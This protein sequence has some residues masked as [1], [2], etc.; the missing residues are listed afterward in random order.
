MSPN[1][2]KG[3]QAMNAL[4]VIVGSTAHGPVTD[5]HIGTHAPPTPSGAFFCVT[6]KTC[7]KRSTQMTRQM[8]GAKMVVQALIDQGVDT[9]SDIPVAL[10]Y[11]FTT[12]FSNK[13]H[14][15]HSGAPRTRRCACRRRLC[16]LDRQTRRVPCDLRPRRDQRG[17][18]LDRRLD[19]QH[20]DHRFDGSGANLHDRLGR[21]PGGRHRWHH[22][23]LH[24]TQLAGERDRQLVRSLHEA[25]HVAT[26][27]RPGPVSVDIPKDVQ[28]ATGTYTESK[29]QSSHYQPQ[30]KGRHG[31]RSPNLVEPSKSRTPVFYTGGGVINSGPAASQLLREL[32]AATGFPITSTLMGLGCYPASGENWLGM[33]GHARAVRGQ[34]GDA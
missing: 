10:C 6:T 27:G 8:T 12:R 30:L 14:Q 3:P 16:P 22:P 13:T 19:G 26:S 2:T 17:D 4:V 9:Y 18:R 20:P 33:L 15:A 25:F 28:F 34:H 7:C 21:V 31:R 5:I 32:V 1:A 29:P 23:P 11:R 24:Q